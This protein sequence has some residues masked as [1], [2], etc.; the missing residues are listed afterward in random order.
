M[1]PGCSYPAVTEDCPPQGLGFTGPAAI[2]DTLLDAKSV[3]STVRRGVV[4]VRTSPVAVTRRQRRG[5]GVVGNI[6]DDD[7]VVLPERVIQRLDFSA[8][9]GHGTGDRRLPAR[10]LVPQESFNPSV[11]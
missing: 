9:R 6:E 5:A 2:L 4:R 1:P 11:V 7:H 10:G 8:Q 3:S